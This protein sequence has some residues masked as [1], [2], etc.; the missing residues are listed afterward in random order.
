MALEGD[1]SGDENALPVPSEE[2]VPSSWCSGSIDSS[3]ET[4]TVGAGRFSW[5]REKGQRARRTICFNEFRQQ[6]WL[7]DC[8]RNGVS[9]R[10]QVERGRSLCTFPR[11]GTVERRSK[12]APLSFLEHPPTLSPPIERLVPGVSGSKETTRTEV[13]SRRAK[14]RFSQHRSLHVA[15]E[16]LAQARTTTSQ[17]GP[18]EHAI[19][20]RLM[21][22][23]TVLVSAPPNRTMCLTSGA[24]IERISVAA[25]F[26]P[27][28]FSRPTTRTVSSHHRIAIPYHVRQH[29][30][31]PYP[32]PP[33][34]DR[35]NRAVNWYRTLPV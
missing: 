19:G 28:F 2:S 20:Q 23:A 33:P 32:P 26:P 31:N 11:V 18:T 7:T 10:L 3:L 24:R 30:L 13:A 21:V 1:T 6:I 5:G 17:Q 25:R 22:T 35:Q 15:Y 4:P 29:R 12:S 34:I 9:D 16:Y 14:S 8:G 27:I